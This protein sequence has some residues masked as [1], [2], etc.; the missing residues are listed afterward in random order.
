MRTW[1]DRLTFGI[2]DVLYAKS[3]QRQTGLKAVDVLHTGLKGEV[4]GSTAGHHQSII[5]QIQTKHLYVLEYSSNKINKAK[6]LY[7]WLKAFH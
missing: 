3:L 7:R 1:L 5:E 2:W 4:S 6:V